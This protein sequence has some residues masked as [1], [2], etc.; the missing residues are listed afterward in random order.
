[1]PSF[2]TL[3]ALTIAASAGYLAARQLLSDDAP[4]QLNRLPVS[5]RTAGYTT[6]ARLLRAQVRTRIA[7]NEA[8]AEQTAAQAEL[9]AEYHRKAGRT[10]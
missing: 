10:P 9:T 3:S 8:R 1:M 7:L 5:L 4:E 6:R 2:K